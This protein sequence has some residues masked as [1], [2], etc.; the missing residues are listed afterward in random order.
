[1]QPIR[2]EPLGLRQKRRD[3]LGKPSPYRFRLAARRCFRAFR[4]GS[5]FI[6]A[7]G[8]NTA[9]GR[10]FVTPHLAKRSDSR[11]ETR[12]HRRLGAAPVFL[13]LFDVAY[14]DHS[15]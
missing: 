6:Q 14:F 10:S 15:L 5:N 1:M 8:E 12:D 11:A 9:K 4:E 7:A 2:V 13:A 3:L